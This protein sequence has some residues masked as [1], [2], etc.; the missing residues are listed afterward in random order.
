MR[1]RIRLGVGPVVTQRPGKNSRLARLAGSLFTM[2]AIC[3]AAMGIWRVSVDVDLAGGF[4]FEDGLLSHWQ[5]WLAAAGLTQYVAWLLSEHA[6]SAE[7][8]NQGTVAA[9]ET[10]NS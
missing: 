2:G 1:V 7:P 3:L 4:L 9:N 5:V 6:R 10:G 8:G